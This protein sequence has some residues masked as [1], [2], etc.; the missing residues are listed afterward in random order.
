MRNH[1]SPWLLLCALATRS[2][3]KAAGV[4]GVLNNAGQASV[5]QSSA[6]LPDQGTYLITNVASGQSLTYT[7]S[8][9][10]VVWKRRTAIAN[11]SIPSATAG[12]RQ[13]VGNHIAPGSGSGSPFTITHYGASTSWI[14]LA[15]GN[16]NK[17]RL[18]VAARAS[19]RTAVTN[20][21]LEVREQSMG[22]L[23]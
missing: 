13:A 1:L 2:S 8:A 19:G 14:R 7:V 16:K 3:A 15:V 22:R 5:L 12:P 4:A 11:G 9:G 6:N 21:R 17:V 18:H 10:H 23:V 20:S